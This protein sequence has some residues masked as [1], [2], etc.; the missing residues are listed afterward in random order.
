M[1]KIENRVED[2]LSEIFQKIELFK[3]EKQ[4]RETNVPRI[5]PS[6]LRIPE[7]KQRP[8]HP[9]ITNRLESKLAN[10]KFARGFVAKSSNFPDIL[11]VIHWL[12]PEKMVHESDD[13][14]NYRQPYNMKCEIFRY[15]KFFFSS[16][17]CFERVPYA[18]KGMDEIVS[19]VTS[20]DREKIP[21]C[22]GD[23]KDKEIH[24]EFV[25]M[26]EMAWQHKPEFRAHLSEL[27]RMLSKMA[28]KYVISN[29]LLP[30]KTI[31]CDNLS[32][33][34]LLDNKELYYTAPPCSD[35]TNSNTIH[36]SKFINN[37]IS[38]QLPDIKVIPDNNRF[39]KINIPDHIKLIEPNITI[40]N[41]RNSIACNN[42]NCIKISDFVS[43]NAKIFQGISVNSFFQI[44][45]LYS[46]IN[47][48]KVEIDKMLGSQPVYAL[49]PYFQQ[50]YSVLSVACW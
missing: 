31:D 15:K 2:K 19:Y 27:Y 8:N 16:E 36:N 43:V 12:A 23:E 29:Y 37:K 41:G 26:I 49:G 30:N 22:K 14:E 34:L 6:Q 32:N 47:D 4:S 10:F 18:D 48:K 28:S 7:I 40:S 33:S 11:K 39:G 25:T 17:L 9:R 50:G 35:N 13:N 24:K 20:G 1:N 45:Q 21:V 3:I 46:L 42:I 44:E 38:I 5:D